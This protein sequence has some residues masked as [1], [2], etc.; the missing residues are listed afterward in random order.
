M[1]LLGWAAF[2]R[3]VRAQ[4]IVTLR[5]DYVEAA[6]AVGAAPARL[7]RHCVLPEVAPILFT[8]FLLTVRWAVLLEATLGLL[9]LGDPGRVSWG[10]MLHQAFSYPLLFVTDA[11]VWWAGPPAL[12]IVLVSLGLMAVG[13]DLD[14]WLNPHAAPRT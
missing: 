13:Q 5:R 9:G 1:G 14:H 6:R 12:A 11:W 2:A 4:V 7:F 3:I 10:L 8:K